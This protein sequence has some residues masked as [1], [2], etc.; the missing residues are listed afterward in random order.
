MAERIPGKS[1]MSKTLYPREIVYRHKLDFTKH[2]KSPF[3]TYCEVHDEPVPTN[4][5]VTCSTPAI[6]LGPTGNLQG[7][8]K[9]LSPATGKMVKQLALTPYTMSDSVI[10]KVEV[11]GK[12]TALPGIFDFADRNGIL[13]K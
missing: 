12:S 3:G 11:Y 1:E 9:F 5:M 13:F 4:T 7:T 10:R 2:Y 8:Y 6:V